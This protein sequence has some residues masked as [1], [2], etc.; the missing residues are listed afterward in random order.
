MPV[1]NP[2]PLFMLFHLLGTPF[3][4]FLLQADCLSY[5]HTQLGQLLLSVGTPFSLKLSP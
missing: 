1:H 3:P 4:A 5:L 2:I